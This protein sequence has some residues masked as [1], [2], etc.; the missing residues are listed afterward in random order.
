[1]ANTD[2]DLMFLSRV[3]E[4]F[5]PQRLT[6]E[7][8]REWLTTSKSG[9]VAPLTAGR[10]AL[11]KKLSVTE[12]VWSDADNINSIDYALEL[13]NR[14]RKSKVYTGELFEK[15]DKKIKEAISRI[16][17]RELSQKGER[18]PDV[19]FKTDYSPNTSQELNRL[20][21]AKKAFREQ[22]DKRRNS[23]LEDS[24]AT[25]IRQSQFRTVKT[26]AKQNETSEAE[27]LERLNEL[28][29]EVQNGRIIR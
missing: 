16:D 18:L 1:M 15:I 21:G 4:A 26:L 5:E 13:R 3:Q 27:T 2:T 24:T 20:Y 8:I 14:A 19:N 28:G 9:K 11:A 12:Q 22:I 29:I 25:Q 6:E 7:N 17:V 23:F 10:K